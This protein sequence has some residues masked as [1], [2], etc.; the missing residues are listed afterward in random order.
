MPLTAATQ[1]RAFL[2]GPLQLYI[3]GRH[4]STYDRLAIDPATGETLAE[5]H[6]IFDVAVP[7]GGRKHPVSAASLAP[8]RWNRT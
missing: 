1:R 6:G 7:F 4:V 3:G 8:K 2:D 5:T